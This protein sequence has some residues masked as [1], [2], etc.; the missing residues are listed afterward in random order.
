MANKFYSANNE[1]P[2]KQRLPSP[3]PATPAGGVVQPVASPDRGG[4]DGDTGQV[5]RGTK[6][7]T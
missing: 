1:M 7:E 3:E 6:K 4:F 5:F 2:V